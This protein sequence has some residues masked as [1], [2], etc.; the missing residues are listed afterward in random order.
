MENGR[1]KWSTEEKRGEE[2]STV[3]YSALE[4][5]RRQDK[6]GEDKT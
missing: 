5:N 1:E 6:R 3:Q 2:K 4:R